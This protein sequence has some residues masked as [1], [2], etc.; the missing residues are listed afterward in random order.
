MNRVV[1][2]DQLDAEIAKLAASIVAKPAVA[3]AMGKEMFY[4]Q[5]ETGTEAAYQ[6]AGQ[7]M[8]CNLVDPAAQ[9]GI[10]AFM[11]KRKPNWAPP[12]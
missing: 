4:R 12:A 1:A 10:D 6:M 9:E 7:T 8:V 2:A 3:I 11:A 5:V